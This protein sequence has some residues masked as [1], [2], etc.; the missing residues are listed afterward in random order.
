[1]FSGSDVWAF[2]GK[3]TGTSLTSPMHPY[4]ARFNGTNWTVTPVPGSG[5]VSATSAISAHDMYAVTGYLASASGTAASPQVLH[6]NGTTWNAMP[7]QPRLVRHAV[8]QTVAARSDSDV[9]IG[10]SQPTS[11]KESSEIIQRWNG[12]SWVSARIVSASAKENSTVL[13]LTG[14]G[15]GSVWALVVDFSTGAEQL[16]D[17]RHGRWSAVFRPRWFLGD[18]ATVPHTS[19]TWATGSIKIRNQ[20]FGVIV[21]HGPA[22]H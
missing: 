9:W 15:R 12:A 7:V 20:Y 14:D 17:F 13:S 5:D 2:G 6:W 8:L 22:P 10:G 3:F 18:L 21:L 4:A 11:K 19:S 1:V 16:S